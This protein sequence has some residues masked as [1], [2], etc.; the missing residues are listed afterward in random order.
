MA[1]ILLQIALFAIH[2]IISLTDCFEPVVL[3][4]SNRFIVEWLPVNF[5]AISVDW[6]GTELIH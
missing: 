1:E 3:M 5:N 4:G 6:N 2:F